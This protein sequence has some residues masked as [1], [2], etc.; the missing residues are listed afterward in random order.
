MRTQVG[1]IG[2]YLGAQE[3]AG[4]SEAAAMDLN[5]CEVRVAGIPIFTDGCSQLDGSQEA[6]LAAHMAEVP[7]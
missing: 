5:H 4:D 3:A 1:K 2:Q 7:C 6:V